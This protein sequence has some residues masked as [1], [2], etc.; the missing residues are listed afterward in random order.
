MLDT[1]Y[2]MINKSN[3]M[4]APGKVV[5]ELSTGKEKGKITHLSPLGIR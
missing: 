4:T 3:I 2:I 5:K 1:K